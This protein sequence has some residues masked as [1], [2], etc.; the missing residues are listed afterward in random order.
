[1]FG[2]SITD[3][4]RAS[5]TKRVRVF[6]ELALWGASSFRAR[7]TP[8]HVSVTRNTVAMPPVPRGSWS[9]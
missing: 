7:S 4:V 1:M 3:M 6:S 9:T 5:C 8:N 2:W